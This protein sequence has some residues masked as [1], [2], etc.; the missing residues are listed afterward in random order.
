MAFMQRR[1]PK[2]SFVA[3]VND[4]PEEKD[5][6]KQLENVIRT[7][8]NYMLLVASQQGNEELAKAALKKGANPNEAC[9]IRDQRTY[10]L[11]EAALKGHPRIVE[12]LLNAGA[13]VN[14][15]K[16][17][18]ESPIADASCYD[19]YEVAKILLEHGADPNVVAYQGLTP[20]TQ[21]E[22]VQMV[23]LLLQY[24]ADPNIPDSD[25]DLP[26]LYRIGNRDKASVIALIKA[27]TDLDHANKMGRSAR[28]RAQML[29]GDISAILN[30]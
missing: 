1:S 9:L 12:V 11:I 26:I 21:V 16:R 13:D 6:A 4:G 24:G 20:L 2:E 7:V 29:V 28:S 3:R 30:S 22:N 18:G 5:E 8:H 23:E 10:P 15:K 17:N 19:H 27:G 25:G 14:I